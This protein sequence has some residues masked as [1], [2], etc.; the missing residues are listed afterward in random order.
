MLIND[1]PGANLGFVT[2]QSYVINTQAYRTQ[3]PD[4]NFAEL[5]Y[6]DTSAP[7]WAEGMTSFIT[8]SY[9]KAMFGTAYAKD[10]PL[11]D[12]TRDRSDV[13]FHFAHIGYEFNDEEIG[14]AQFLNVPLTADKALAAR[15]GYTEFMYDITLTGAAV[16]NM[17]GLGNQTAVTIGTAPADG[18][19][20][21]T[22]W[23][24]NAGTMTK[25]VEQIM[26]DF[27]GVITGIFTG[28]TTV[29]MADTVLLPYA[30]MSRLASVLIPGTNETLLAFIMRSNFYTLRTGQQLRVI[31]VL[32]LDALGTGGTRR[33]VAYANRQDVVKL[34]LPAPHR[35]KPA[36]Q[37]GAYNYLV[38]G[39]FR[40]GGVEVLR[41]GAFR[42]L[43]GI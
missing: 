40:T 2:N 13:S 41:T 11:A 22:T 39:W 12:I 4:L 38:P 9:G 35:F 26:R 33:M 20:G 14:R 27:N 10:V 32:G 6:V 7:E 17:L 1:A 3:Y 8:G 43:D 30:T 23:F 29:E 25:T 34:H 19:A 21:A 28:S 15:R 31:G 5:V 18:T 36:M 16:K 37:N 42:Y 24:D